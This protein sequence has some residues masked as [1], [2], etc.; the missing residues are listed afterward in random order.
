M[1]EKIERLMFRAVP[2]WLLLFAIIVLACGTAIFSASAVFVERGGD[3]GLPGKIAHRTSTLPMT[4]MAAKEE[5]LEED[6]SVAHA[7]PLKDGIEIFSSPQGGYLA[8]NRTDDEFGY[9]K[10]SLLDIASGE[11]VHNWRA[12]PSWFD[13]LDAQGLTATRSGIG[14]GYVDIER[15]ELV[16]LVGAEGRLIK[17]DADS[18]LVWENHEYIYHHLI[19]LDADGNIW[20]PT[21]IDAHPAMMTFQPQYRDDG[22]AQISAQGEVLYHKSVTDI[23]LQN[24]LENLLFMKLVEPD[25][26][27]LNSVDVADADTPYWKRGDV[28][29][30]LRH[31]SMVILFRPSTDKVIWY[32]VG[33]WL[34]QHD[35]EFREDG[36]IS[37]FGN[38]V[39]TNHIDRTTE[40][41]PYRYGHNTIYVHDFKTGQTTKPYDAQMA[42]SP[43][44]TVTGGAVSYAPSGRFVINYDNQ[45][46]ADIYSSSGTLVGR[47]A[48]LNAAGRAVRGSVMLFDD[49]NYNWLEK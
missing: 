2:L 6:V 39:V 48:R 45:A 29:L 37:V 21:Q 11:E 19:N 47:Y 10:V 25:Q 18:Q 7:F 9:L 44:N 46:V 23:L 1:L 5:L 12:L 42:A 35:A 43:V 27:H 16:T 24:G 30:S 34:N 26:I 38:D 13:P 17:V 32:Q 15:G 20:V 36:Q 31:L 3:L 33:P 40:K 49:G 4:I 8:V 22:F 41:S 28:L 14:M